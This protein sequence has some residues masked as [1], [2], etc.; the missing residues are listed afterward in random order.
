MT[1]NFYFAYVV[2]YIAN[3]FQMFY[4]NLFQTAKKAVN[5]FAHKMVTSKEAWAEVQAMRENDKRMI[6]SLVLSSFPVF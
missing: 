6:S 5:K 4:D 2:K 1:S 3:L